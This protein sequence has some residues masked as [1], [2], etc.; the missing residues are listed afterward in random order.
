ME[1]I[2][3]ALKRNGI[4]RK[5][6]TSYYKEQN[7]EKVKEYLEKIENISQESI[8]YVDESEIQGF[9]YREHMLPEEKKYMTV[10]QERST[11]ERI[12]WQQK[13]EKKLFLP[14]SMTV[15]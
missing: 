8:N 13:G 2:R 3:K 6:K 15:P 12:L 5:K 9:L 1:A 11:K 4:T 7:K 14:G 10:F